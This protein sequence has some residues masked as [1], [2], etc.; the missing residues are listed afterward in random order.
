MTT[1]QGLLEKFRETKI[2]MKTEPNLNVEAIIQQ[3]D[4]LWL[5][6]APQIADLRKELRGMK[7]AGM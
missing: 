2:P 4:K 5:P 1:E 7:E 6:K 3:F